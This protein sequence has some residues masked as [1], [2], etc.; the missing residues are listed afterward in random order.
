MKPIKKLALAFAAVFLCFGAAACAPGDTDKSDFELIAEGTE[1]V[2]SEEREPL[3]YASFDG[4]RG[5][6]ADVMPVGSFSGPADRIMS[7]KGNKMEP[8]VRQSTFD[9]LAGAGV[10]YIVDFLDDYATAPAVVEERMALAGNAGIR[11]LIN[12]RSAVNMYGAGTLEPRALA[13]ALKPFLDNPGFGGL[14]GR[15]EPYYPNFPWLKMSN[16]NFDAALELLSEETGVRQKAILYTN[17]VGPAAPSYALNGYDYSSTMAYDYYMEGYL[18]T[19]PN[20]LMY[21]FYP[22]SINGYHQEYFRS[23]SYIRGAAEK[24]GIPWWGFVQV[25]WNFDHKNGRPPTEGEFHWNWNTV[26]A[27][28]AKGLCFFPGAWPWWLSNTEIGFDENSL[29]NPYGTKNI[30][31]H[32]AHKDAAQLR[33]VDGYLMQAKHVGLIA[34]GDSP[35][36]IPEADLLGDGWRELTGVTGDPALI[37]CF[38]YMGRTALYAVNNS[39]QKDG[40]RITLKFGQKYGY[41]VI[42]RG[43]TVSVAGTSLPLVLNGGEAALV[44]LK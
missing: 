2:R 19:K 32:Y 17:I 44:V 41:D 3:P 21:D 6:G 34:T 25:G 1:Y 37:G 30:W 35:V 12:Y 7:W 8:F 10:N 42:Q 14:Y 28:G 38:D 43:E 36:P 39:P 23:N 31:W 24:A 18:G 4:L 33:A 22:M 29:V 16:A 20:Y 13:D 27:Y 15:D 11:T 26:L 40:A 5:Y 9:L